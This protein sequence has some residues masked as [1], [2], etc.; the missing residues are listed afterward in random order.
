MTIQI[1]QD[2]SGVE[3]VI[4]DK[5]NEEFISMPKSIYDEQQAEQSTP[6]LS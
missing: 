1:V 3:H 2:S 6:N 5:G 4:I